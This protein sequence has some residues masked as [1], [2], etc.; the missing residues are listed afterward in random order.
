MRDLD[1]WFGLQLESL[2]QSMQKWRMHDDGR[3][4]GCAVSQGSEETAPVARG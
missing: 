3:A 2:L 4:P 1:E